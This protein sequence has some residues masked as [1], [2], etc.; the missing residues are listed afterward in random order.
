[1]A[2]QPGLRPRIGF[3]ITIDGYEIASF[4]SLL[5]SPVPGGQ[6]REVQSHELALVVQKL[7][8]RNSGSSSSSSIVLKAGVARHSALLSRLSP[9]SVVSRMT[10][11]VVDSNG[12]TA[13]SIALPPMKVVRSTTPLAIGG[14]EVSIEELMLAPT[15]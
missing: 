6:L 2:M 1:M 10:I 7:S 14:G 3:S 15:G 11:A 12:V 8:G 9:A 4:A 5:A 13:P